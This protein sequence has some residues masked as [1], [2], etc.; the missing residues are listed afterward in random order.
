MAFYVVMQRI[1]DVKYF[2]VEVKISYD[3]SKERNKIII[4]SIL[5]EIYKKNR[6]KDMNLL[7]KTSLFP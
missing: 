3:I 7:Q 1:S 4:Y 2:L 6:H 5:K